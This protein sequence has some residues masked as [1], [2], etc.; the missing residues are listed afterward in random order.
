MKKFFIIGES[1]TRVDALEKVTGKAMF[2]ADYR[3]PGM[4]HLKMVRSPYP[5]ARIVQIDTSKAERFPGVRGVI[6]PEDA[7]ERRAGITLLDRH[8]LPRDGFVRF[9]GEPVVLVAADTPEIAEEAAEFV[10]IDYEILPAV[11]DVEEA[12]KKD[13]PVILHP[14]RLNYTHEPHPRYPY[15]HVPDIC[16]LQNSAFI[17]VGDVEKGFEESDLVV[18]N[19][20]VAESVQ[21]CPI[22]THV[23]AAWVEADGTLVVRASQQGYHLLRLSLSRLF[24][25]PLSKVR[26]LGPY[27]GGAFGSKTSRIPASVVALAA[28]KLGK[29]VQLEYPR[30]EDLTIGGRN[31]KIIIMLKHGVKKD[32]TLIALEARIIIDGGAYGSDM[33]VF[34]PRTA[35]N[36]LAVV[37]RIPNVKADAFAIYTNHQPGTN[38][39]GVHVPPVSWAVEQQMDIIG[40]KL[41]MEPVQL[42]MK[43]ILEEGE[44]NP[45][46]EITENIQ[47]KECLDKVT[48]WSGWGK[49]FEVGVGWA[50]G[51]GFGIGPCLVGLGYS[52]TSKVKV[53]SDGTL[54]VYFGSSELGQGA[55]TV[56]AQI[57]AEEFKVPVSKVKVIYGD[58]DITPWDWDNQASRT[59]VSTGHAVIRACQDAK[60]QIFELAA[61]K[62]GVAPEDLDIADGNIYCKDFPGNSISLKELFTPAGFVKGI[63]EILGRGEFTSTAPPMDPKTG[64]FKKLAIWSFVAYGVEVAVNLETGE[65]KVLRLIGALDLGQPI[66]RKM[67]E[68]QIEG[69]IG[70][71]IGFTLFE[72]LIYDQ[73][74]LLNPDL[75]NYKVPSATEIPSGGNCGSLI[76]GSPHKDGPYGAKGF[77]EAPL[78]ALSGAIANAVYK[79]ISKRLYCLPMTR[80]KVLSAIKT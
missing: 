58:T 63:G 39:R 20:Y 9:V 48:E 29:P 60:R 4:L 45:A 46:G 66:N 67:C 70:M 7:P 38:L 75:I 11:F 73:G 33:M 54:Q 55:Q 14:D 77:G 12:M 6:R 64:Q 30:E 15:I 13:S 17:R 16:N 80:E 42:R 51:R 62:I 19:K 53:C 5:H 34:L 74:N 78:V 27:V 31:S 59:T 47:V 24:N 57:V 21:H 79:A 61:P 76:V 26:V 41:G 44:E 22:E 25:I 56:V 28:L 50:S 68:Q 35:L 72:Q 69:G 3:M 71:G 65:V 36:G 2:T 23:I 49:K 1:P 52:A 40:E 10:E 18:Q 8:V 37:Y 43:N 32:G